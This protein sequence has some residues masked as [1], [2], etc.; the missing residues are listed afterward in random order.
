MNPIIP[1]FID[2]SEFQWR[3]EMSLPQNTQISRVRMINVANPNLFRMLSFESLT[4]PKLSICAELIYGVRF[5]KVFHP[6]D[7]TRPFKIIDLFDGSENCFNDEMSALKYVEL[8]MIPPPPPLPQLPSLP[9]SPPILQLSPQESSLKL[10]PIKEILADARFHPYSKSESTEPIR[11][12]FDMKLQVTPTT[13][14]LLSSNQMEVLKRGNVRILNENSHITF[15]IDEFY[16]FYFA[17]SKKYSNFFHSTRNHLFGNTCDNQW[18]IYPKTTMCMFSENEKFKGYFTFDTQ[19]KLQSVEET[20]DVFKS[21]PY[22]KKLGS[23]VRQPNESQC[24][25]LSMNCL[26]DITNKDY[27]IGDKFACIRLVHKEKNNSVRLYHQIQDNEGNPTMVLP[28]TFNYLNGWS[29]PAND[30]HYSY[31]DKLGVKFPHLFKINSETGK[32]FWQMTT[33]FN[34]CSNSLTDN[35]KRIICS[36]SHEKNRL[37]NRIELDPDNCPLIGSHFVMNVYRNIKSH[38][39]KIFILARYTN[40]ETLSECHMYTRPLW[41]FSLPLK[42][43]HGTERIECHRNSHKKEISLYSGQI[44]DMH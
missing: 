24:F 32:F 11:P 42:F 44:Y 17:K 35:H 16:Q 28:I 4:D 41:E 40:V 19:A 1:Q 8:R 10:P 22:I 43:I 25:P 9:P 6:E 38:S 2:P 14:E 23:I 21:Y 15:R 26:R 12:N 30:Y 3:I 39:E 31:Y 27:S 37:G 13:S 34:K 36:V 20:P 33:W 18:R 7:P 29:N 5:M